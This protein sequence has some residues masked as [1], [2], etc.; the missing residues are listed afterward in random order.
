MKIITVIPLKKGAWR[1]NLT[2]FTASE[3][4]LGSIVTVPIRSQQTDALVVDSHEASELKSS[5][6]TSDWQLRKVTK[7]K[8]TNYLD[9]TFI[10]ATKLT[11]DYFIAQTGSIIKSLIPQAILDELPN[12]KN[13]ELNSATEEI[14][15]EILATQEPD[16]S[17]LARYKSLI[18]ESFAKKQSI[19]ICLPTLTDIE[20]FFPILSKGIDNYVFIGHSGLSKKEQLNLWKKALET[21]H[22]ILIIATPLFLSIPRQDIST[23]IIDREN[24]PAYKMNF[25]PFVDWRFFIEKLTQAKKIRLILGDSALR[26]ETVY[27]LGKNEVSA[28][29]TIKYRFPT[30]ASSQIIPLTGKDKDKI[31][32]ATSEK[33]KERIE[34]ALD[35]KERFFIYSGR[36]GLTPL[37]ICRDCGTV[38]ECDFC[39]SPL[40]IHQSNKINEK[41]FICHKCGQI[42]EIEDECRV[43][44]GQRLALVGFGVEKLI[45]EIKNRFPSSNIYR[46]DSD[47]TKTPKKAQEIVQQ[48]YKTPGAILV[49]TELALNYLPEKIDNIAVVSLDSLLAMPDWRASEKLFSLLLRLKQLANKNFI[50]QTRQPEEK[51][52]SYITEG[53]LID[54]Y[55]DEISERQ[56]LGYPPFKVLIKISL[57]GKGIEIKKE[58]TKL[59]KL[60]DKWRP[61][62]YPNL[63]K[64]L[65][66]QDILNLLIRLPS[67]D[68]PDQELLKILKV[69]PPNFLI[70]VD[71]ESVL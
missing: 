40:S 57:A 44:H 8:K 38:M 17:R 46:L 34:N 36:R 29:G 20:K 12:I 28:L 63:N 53:N 5:L 35:R 22:P 67:S 48:F 25:R 23:I 13:V 16:E 4:P 60:L 9:Q 30:N 21:K 7:I 50:I 56:Q 19:F 54:F 70:N 61:L 6:K 58:M 51:I 42:V 14:V 41:I 11:A 66:G 10:N 69:L 64:D 52:F 59:I 2:Y 32:E 39:H 45:E 65:K 3:I 31:L 24:S 55:R 27:R 37:T 1:D 15:T 71:P 43:C 18:R 26:S 68:W 47:N 62:A 49:G 33:L